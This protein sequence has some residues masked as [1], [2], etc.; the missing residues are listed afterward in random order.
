[1][2]GVDTPPHGVSLCTPRIDAIV[3]LYTQCKN[4]IAIKFEN[5]NVGKKLGL[6]FFLVLLLTA[7]ITG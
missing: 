7:L 2:R 5:I 1:M 6:G 4:R 3:W